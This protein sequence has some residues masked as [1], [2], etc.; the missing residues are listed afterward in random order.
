MSPTVF[1]QPQSSCLGGDPNRRWCDEHSEFFDLEC[2]RCTAEE[3]RG[4]L[5]LVAGLALGVAIVL[6]AVIVC[7]VA[8]CT[9]GAR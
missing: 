7:L 1:H 6:L 5:G 2:P 3:V 8:H 9:V 4:G